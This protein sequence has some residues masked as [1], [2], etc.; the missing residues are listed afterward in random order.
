MRGLKVKTIIQQFAGRYGLAGVAAACMGAAALFLPLIS[1]GCGEPAAEVQTVTETTGT[2]TATAPAYRRQALD[3]Y[4]G[5]AEPRAIDWQGMVSEADRLLEDGFNTVTL[6]P[7]VLITPRAG[8]QPRVIME[9]EAASAEML[10][11]DFHE[12]GLAVYL[13]PTTSAAGFSE[14]IEPT[15]T[16]MAHL[17]EDARRWSDKAESKQAEL[18]S[19]LSRYNLVL[20]TDAANRWSARVLPLV[21]SRFTGP[22]VAQ[23]VADL[24]APPPPGEAH[25]F[26]KLDL[27]GYDYLMLDIFPMGENYDA[28]A[29][30]KYVSDVLSR[31]AL[32]VKRDGLKGV[33]VEFGAWREP[34]GVDPVDGP[35]LGEQAQAEMADR[36]LKVAIPQTRG[37]FYHGW[38]LPGR[39][40]E[41]YQVE[42]ILKI[43]F[44]R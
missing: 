7:P 20:G 28:P 11:D 5:I 32:V 36:F 6:S 43:Y 21:R 14:Q 27:R 34:A 30:D 41:N 16:V 31:A 3:F 22:V 39:G 40:A 15:D 17:E 19:P 18:F 1:L 37:V 44:T 2:A 23:A 35:I 33:M 8:G 29:F 12:N 25:D 4:K 13:A 38:T 9:G 26:E 42:E 24:D 10:T